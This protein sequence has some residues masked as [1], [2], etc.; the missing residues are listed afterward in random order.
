M[1]RRRTEPPW[2]TSGEL[3]TASL[4][5]PGGHHRQDCPRDRHGGKQDARY[6]GARQEDRRGD[7]DQ[8][9][10]APSD[11]QEE[12]PHRAKGR[13]EGSPTD[14]STT[15]VALDGPHGSIGPEPL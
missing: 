8:G 9:P 5:Q 7:E 1:A 4:P 10:R 2:F 12:P 3:L 13:E 11:G 14:E 6:R 15:R